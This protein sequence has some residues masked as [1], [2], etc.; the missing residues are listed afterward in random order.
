M[1]SLLCSFVQ[2]RRKRPFPALCCVGWYSNH[3]PTY[4]SFYAPFL[5]FQCCLVEVVRQFFLRC[6]KN[7]RPSTRHF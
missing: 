3:L 7:W 4:L 2:D 5:L 1:N 6:K